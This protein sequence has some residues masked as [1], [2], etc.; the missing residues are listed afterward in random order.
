M[1]SIT[2]TCEV[3]T[4]MFLGDATG[5]AELRPPAIKAALRFWW[6]ALHADLD[7]PEMHETETLIFGGG[8]DKAQRSSFDVVIISNVKESKNENES[9]VIPYNYSNHHNLKEI[10]GV[11]NNRGIKYLFYTFLYLKKEGKYIK[12]G[13]TFEIKLIF[14]NDQYINDVL[15]AFW[16]LTHLGNL[17]SRA[18]RGAGSFKVTAIDVNGLEELKLK[19]K[20]NADSVGDIRTF[21]DDNIKEIKRLLSI[22][23]VINNTH[24]HILDATN[25]FS[26][27]THNNWKSALNEI[28]EAMKDRRLKIVTVNGK[29]RP[30]S[31]INDDESAAFGL[32]VKHK[33]YTILPKDYKRRASPII[34]KII[35]HND[36]FSW[37]IT[38][39]SG[40][41][42]PSNKNKLAKKQKN[43]ITDIGTVNT[44]ALNE[45]FKDIKRNNSL[46][47][48]ALQIKP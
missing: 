30:T 28:G 27:N 48:K 31:K 7:L 41:F 23:S 18:R 35:N 26:G 37:I 13:S 29:P 42:L 47:A 12:P 4:P 40:E 45:F 38:H 10:E 21:Y 5:G 15:S 6:R 19:L 39:L 22:G 34:I 43:S 24:S 46:N 8:G 9:D 32:P 14:Y 36:K 2:F 17:G 25:Y 33:N 20:F 16:L 1:K 3:L 44:K 11:D